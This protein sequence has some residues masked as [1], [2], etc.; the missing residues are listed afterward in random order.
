MMH[1]QYGHLFLYQTSTNCVG[2]QVLI[3]LLVAFVLL[4]E[5][6]RLLCLFVEEMG[7]DE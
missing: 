2:Y 4:M 6:F 5:L 7:L 3:Y 1:W